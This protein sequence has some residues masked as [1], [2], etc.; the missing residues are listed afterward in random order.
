MLAAFSPMQ[1]D[2]TQIPFSTLG[3]H[4]SFSIL[5]PFW[6]QPGV[7][8]RSMRSTRWET[9]WMFLTRGD[10]VLEYR[11]EATPTELKLV[12]Q[13]GSGAVS[14]CIPQ[15]DLAFFR[16][17]GGVGLR[18][19]SVPGRLQH[20][21]PVEN[22]AW[23]VNAPPA[24]TQYLVQSV[25]GT[26]T[27][28]GRVRLRDTCHV[29]SGAFEG[30]WTILNLAPDGDSFEA[31]VEE[32]PVAPRKL[33]KPR[34]F[35]EALS[36]SERNWRAFEATTPATAPA[37]AKEA[38]RAMFLLYTSTVNP[39]TG[40]WIRRPTVLMSKNWMSQCW[41]WDHAFNA[42]ALSYTQPDLAWDQWMTVFDH[43]DESGALPDCIGAG[44]VVWNY[45]KPPIHGWALRKMA[46]NPGV[47]TPERRAQAYE[48]LT[49]WT[50]FWLD[51]R[52]HDGDGI[53]E[54]HD[55]NEAQDNATSFDKG[56][57]AL[58]PDLPAHLVTQMDYLAELATELGK[59]AEAAQWRARSAEMIDAMML[60]LWDGEQFRGRNAVTGEQPDGDP[61]L[62]HLAIVAGDR[63]P[64][65]V[66]EKIVRVLQ[67]DGPFIT[68][69]GPATESLRSRHYLR[70]SYWR[71]PI[72][73]PTT[74]MLVDGLARVGEQAL[75]REIARRYCDLCVRERAFAENYDAES[76][77]PL[78]DLGYTWGASA[79]LILAREFLS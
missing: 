38:R 50:R 78:R 69:F 67:P 21:F 17:T 70:D 79:Y 30:S 40:S 29:G 42:I 51:C 16:G 49:R 60:R 65:H 10:T 12:A 75:A 48:L 37:Y 8:L 35:A 74:V 64:K 59:D 11:A 54:Y 5:P 58:L 32:F 57:P 62:N 34:D 39:T 71:G 47:L 68:Q 44:A 41:S 24:R 25:R 4:L 3:S 14:I 19:S 9:F 6:N 31:W 45:L 18:L 2:L 27:G 53:P 22:G 15:P 66:V 46:R 43:Q 28:Q 56:S 23:H 26:L 55:G 36:V 76:G 77:T 52:D 72:W 33:P 13:D 1:I 20:S 73:G 61:L 7:V 63:L